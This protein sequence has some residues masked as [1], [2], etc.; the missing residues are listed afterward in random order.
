MADVVQKTKKWICI[1]CGYVYDPEWG[2]E[3]GGIAPGVDYNNF[4]PK[5]RTFLI[6]ANVSF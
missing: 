5:T 1:P 3:D 2:D 4:Y 6:G